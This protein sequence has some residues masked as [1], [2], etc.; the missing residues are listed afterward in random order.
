M[1]VDDL[2]YDDKKLDRLRYELDDDGFIKA[3]VSKCKQY[4]NIEIGFEED[5]DL[6]E[7]LVVSS[8]EYLFNA[9][10]KY[11]SSILYR[12]LICL[13]VFNFYEKRDNEKMNIFISNM[14]NQLRYSQDV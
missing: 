8:I 11:Q 5:D 12:Q 7:I 13:L 9:G 14:I 6:I 10:V 2:T 3:M 1:S 4:L